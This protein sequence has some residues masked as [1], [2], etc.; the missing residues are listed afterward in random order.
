[1]SNLPETPTCSLCGGGVPA[2]EQCKF[3]GEWVC[4]SHALGKCEAEKQPLEL[5]W[6]CEFCK[7]LQSECDKD[8]CCKACA[9]LQ[10][11][12]RQEKPWIPY[13][14]HLIICK[15]ELHSQL[16]RLSSERMGLARQLNSAYE[17]AVLLEYKLT[18]EADKKIAD[19]LA[20]RIA[21]VRYILGGGDT[22][23]NN[24]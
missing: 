21:E 3:C 8:V 2:V 16:T 18:D 1:M 24:K 10:T 14:A 23:A 17:A 7:T 9:D 12:Q 13:G 4:Q 20:G 5:D 11:T 19:K 6:M 22:N 15:A